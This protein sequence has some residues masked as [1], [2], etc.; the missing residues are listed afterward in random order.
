MTVITESKTH[1]I[2][3]VETAEGFLFAKVPIGN[4]GLAGA[5]DMKE[6]SDPKEVEKYEKSVK[7]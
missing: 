6:F 1:K 5:T 4:Q 2:V 7:A 3:K